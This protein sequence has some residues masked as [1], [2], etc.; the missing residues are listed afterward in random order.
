MGAQDEGGHVDSP[1]PPDGDGQAA[2]GHEAQLKHPQGTKLQAQ[3][4]PEIDALLIHLI[5]T[6]VNARGEDALE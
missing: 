2:A 6:S 1:D 3:M 5:T 4:L